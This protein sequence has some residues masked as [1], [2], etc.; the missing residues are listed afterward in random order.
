MSKYMTLKEAAEKIN[1]KKD[2]V[3]NWVKHGCN[4][5]K[6]EGVKFGHQWMVTQEQLDDFARRCAENGVTDGSDAE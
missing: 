1:R 4:G 5:I 6:L 2:T 3:W